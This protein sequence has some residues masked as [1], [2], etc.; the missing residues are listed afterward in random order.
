MAGTSHDRAC[1]FAR[2]LPRGI[3]LR[4]P[5]VAFPVPLRYKGPC[6][7][8]S[9]YP[10]PLASAMARDSDPIVFSTDRPAARPC[11]RCG[12]VPCACDRPAA[13][14]VVPAQTV[15]RLGLEKKG[16]RGKAVTVVRGLPPGAAEAPDLLRRLKAHCGVGGALKGDALELQ[17]DLR[18]RAGAFLAELGFTVRRAGG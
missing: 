10:V 18:D 17:G 4:P 7:R 9:R 2:A 16:R 15:L 6:I 13:A 12:A 11:R 8:P 14:P 5:T 3:A 1:D